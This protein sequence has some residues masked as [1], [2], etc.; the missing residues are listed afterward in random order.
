[1][2]GKITADK[3]LRIPK[4]NGQEVGILS[5]QLADIM[6]ENPEFTVP[7]VTSA[8]LRTAGLKSEDIKKYVRDLHNACKAFK[9]QSLLYDEQAY[10]LVR[11]VNTHVKGEAKYNAQMKGKF[12]PLFKFFE[13][14]SNKTEEPTP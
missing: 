6:D 2:A 4:V 5:Q 13:R 10:I 8:Q 3:I 11:R 9:Q 7:E 1:M 12:A 14:A